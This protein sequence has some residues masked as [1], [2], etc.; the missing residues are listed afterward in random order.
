M[1]LS[2]RSNWLLSGAVG[3]L[4]FANGIVRVVGW[5][6]VLDLLVAVALMTGGGLIAGN[7]VTWLRN[8]EE[9]DDVVWTTRKTVV[10]A[11]A[12]V[13]LALLLVAAVYAVVVGPS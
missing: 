4:L 5:S 3:F 7:A 13:L 11:A 9:V 1:G 12:T 10:N 8:P 6:S 2:D